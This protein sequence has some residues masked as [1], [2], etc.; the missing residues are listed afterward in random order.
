L[1]RH[2]AQQAT[3]SGL[4]ENRGRK[5]QKRTRGFANPGAINIEWK[6]DQE[7]R[8]GTKKKKTIARNSL[9]HRPMKKG[10]YKGGGWSRIKFPA[11]WGVKDDREK[12]ENEKKG[13]GRTGIKNLL[14]TA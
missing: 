6:G 1:G 3:A 9:T 2:H 10:K 8:R 13:E 4:P 7:K 5:E 12:K 14:F 11:K